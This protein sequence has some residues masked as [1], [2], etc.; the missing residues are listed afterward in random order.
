MVKEKYPYPLAMGVSSPFLFII[1][2][3]HKTGELSSPIHPLNLL[4]IY[5]IISVWILCLVWMIP[6]NNNGEDL[7]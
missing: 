1:W 5:I 2:V 6:H 3:A 4:I 7:F